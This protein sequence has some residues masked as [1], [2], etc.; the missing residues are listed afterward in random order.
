MSAY[1][2]AIGEELEIQRWMEAGAPSHRDLWRQVDGTEHV[3]IRPV[4][5]EQ[6]AA[7]LNV[8]TKYVRRRL[9]VLEAMD[10]PGAYRISDS[11]RA[12]WRI[13]PAA[14]DRLTEA[15][16]PKPAAPPRGNRKAPKKR[17]ATR[18]E[19]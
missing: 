17:S 4:T 16:E 6:A 19:M 5:I 10:P 2:G 14:L 15:V 11:A 8:S 3:D 13:V 18:W 7:R 9:P 1:A 12:A